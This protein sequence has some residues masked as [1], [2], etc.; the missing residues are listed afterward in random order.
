MTNKLTAQTAKTAQENSFE[1]R[2][3]LISNKIEAITKEEKAS[4]KEELET[5]NKELETGTITKEQAD[6]K[7]LELAETRSK[8]IETRIDLAQDELK[9]LVKEKVEGKITDFHKN[10]YYI[11][12]GWKAKDSIRKNRGESRTTTQFVLAVTPHS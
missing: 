4:L 9:Q 11:N 8:N 1:N 10:A 6:K 5:V 12:L 2:V 7:K 3:R